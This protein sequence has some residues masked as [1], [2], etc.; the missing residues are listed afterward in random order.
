MSTPSIP[1][2]P[3]VNRAGLLLRPRYPFIEWLREHLD[4]E[5]LVESPDDW[6]PNLYLIPAGMETPLEEDAWLRQHYSKLFL[7]TLAELPIEEDRWP[8]DRS[9]DLFVEWFEVLFIANV[10]DMEKKG[11]ER[12][13]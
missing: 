5:W 8:A 13:Q 6:E 9:I 1:E 7:H 12:H 4:E 10:F 3:A 11:L 2:Y